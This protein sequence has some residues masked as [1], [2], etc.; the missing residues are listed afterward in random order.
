[1]A[2]LVDPDKVVSK[3]IAVLSENPDQQMFLAALG[4]RASKLLGVSL[5]DALGEQKFADFIRD[6][7]TE[8]VAIS[9]TKDRLVAR[10]VSSEPSQSTLPLIGQ[11]VPQAHGGEASVSRKYAPNFWNAFLRPARRHQCRAIDPKPPFKWSDFQTGA[12]PEGWKEIDASLLAPYPVSSDWQARKRAAGVA[13]EKWCE[14]Q[15]LN[16]ETFV[17]DYDTPTPTVNEVNVTGA[18]KLLAVIDEIPAASRANQSLNLEFI[19]S[20]L[21]RR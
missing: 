6:H 9:G 21:A 19:R 8:Q 7:L 5:R 14:Q 20:L 10:L 1:M 11:V 4:N 3:I 13:I 15:Q 17:A 2:G 12:V 18:A 16:P